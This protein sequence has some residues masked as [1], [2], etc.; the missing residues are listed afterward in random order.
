[1]DLR[2]MCHAKAPPEYGSGTPD[3]QRGDM[4]PEER[5]RAALDRKAK[6]LAKRDSWEE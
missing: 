5:A 2:I 1:M 3:P 4:T 6:V